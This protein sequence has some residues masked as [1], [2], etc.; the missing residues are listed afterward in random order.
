M[1]AYQYI[2]KFIWNFSMINASSLELTK[3]NR[4]FEQTE[5]HED[6]FHLLKEKICEAF[7]SVLPNVQ[8]LFKHET[9]AYGYKIGI[10]LCK[11]KEDLLLTILNC[12]KSLK[13]TT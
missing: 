7:I 13:R 5:K 9:D 12:F 4:R 10:F 11:K 1:G 2:K 3:V 6:T 8:K